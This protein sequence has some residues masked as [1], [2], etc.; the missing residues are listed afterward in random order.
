MKKAYSGPPIQISLNS[1]DFLSLNF[2]SLADI[3][4]KNAATAANGSSKIQ[5][6]HPPVCLLYA[7][8]AQLHSKLLF[9]FSNIIL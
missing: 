1:E 5:G 6:G 7:K 9:I 8:S 3:H 4:V 2:F